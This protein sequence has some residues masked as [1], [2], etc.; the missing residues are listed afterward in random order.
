[1]T[2]GIN[3]TGWTPSYAT[4]SDIITADLSSALKQG[5][6]PFQACNSVLNIIEKYSTQF[7]GSL[8]VPTQ[9]QRTDILTND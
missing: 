2:C 9:S 7:K 6:S 5:N 4:V 8:G 1:M 3:S